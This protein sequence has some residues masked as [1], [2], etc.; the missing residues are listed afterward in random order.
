[1]R[2]IFTFFVEKKQASVVNEHN[3]T[4]LVALLILNFIRDKRAL[5]EVS[6]IPLVYFE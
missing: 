5:V 2:N 6:F 4:R 1:M 3:I